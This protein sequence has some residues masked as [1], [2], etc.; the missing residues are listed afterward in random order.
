MII[1]FSSFWASIFPFYH[2]LHQFRWRDRQNLIKNDQSNKHRNFHTLGRWNDVAHCQILI[3]KIAIALLISR[4]VRRLCSQAYLSFVMYVHIVR[5]QLITV[6]LHE[7]NELPINVRFFR[8]PFTNLS[9][10]GCWKNAIFGQF[11]RFNNVNGWRQKNA[12]MYNELSL[13]FALK[14]HAI[15][16]SDI[17][18]HFSRQCLNERG[19]WSYPVNSA[20]KSNISMV[21][22][23]QILAAKFTWK[24]QNIKW[25]KESKIA[26]AIFMR[27]TT[28]NETTTNQKKI[29]IYTQNE[30]SLSLS[31]RSFV[32]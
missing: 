25:S 14:L 23:S 20:H 19:G 12:E 2:N 26:I 28:R 32:L 3:K 18:S 1:E 29:T 21:L 15:H 30:R 9:D 11:N 16:I 8:S 17:T 5:N 7:S 22:C 10:A 24:P 31:H 6:E 13:Q 4:M 27:K